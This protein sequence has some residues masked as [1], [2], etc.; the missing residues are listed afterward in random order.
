[1]S[2]LTVISSDD[3]PD[4]AEQKHGQTVQP[5]QVEASTPTDPKGMGGRSRGKARGRSVATQQSAL[6][7]NKKRKRHDVDENYK[8][9]QELTAASFIQ[10]V[11]PLYVFIFLTIYF[12]QGLDTSRT[13]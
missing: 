2:P 12:F 6:L 3:D 4:A 7:F 9:K 13:T 11:R 5:S 10:T 1:M 8:F